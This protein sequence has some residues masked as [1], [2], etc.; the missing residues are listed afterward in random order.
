[1][2]KHLLSIVLILILLTFAAVHAPA[3][4]DSVLTVIPEDTVGFVY[5]PDLLGLNDEINTVLTELISTNPP[6]NIIA[7]RLAETFGA[8]FETLEELEELGLDLNK[9]FAVFLAGVNPLIPSAAVHLKDPVMVKQLIEMEAEGSRATTHNGMTYYTTGEEGA[10]VLLDDV[11]VYSGSTKVCE[12]AIDIYKKVIPSIATNADYASLE[13]DTTSGINDFVAY[14]A[15]EPIVE[16]LH[17][18]LTEALFE[19]QAEMQSETET[20]PQLATTLGVLPNMI[21]GIVGLLDQAKTL[22]ITLQLN[23]SDLQISPFLKFKSDSES[24]AYIRQ[25]PKELVQLNYLPQTAF[26]NGSMHLQQEDIIGLTTGMMRL[27]VP[28][29][30]NADKEQIE[31]AFQEFA[32][33]MTDFY[34]LLGDEMALSFNIGDSLMPD[35]LFVYDAPDEEKVKAYMEEGYLAYLRT[36]QLL[37]RA[38]GTGETADM[39]EGASAG[40]AEIYSGVEI[41]SYMLPNVSASFSQLPPEMEGLAPKQWNTY[42]AIKAGKLLLSMSANAQSIRD[43]LDRMTGM[44]TGFDQGEGYSKLIGALT[45]KNNMLFAI[46]PITVVKH[47]AQLIAQTDPNVGMILIILANIPETY[48]IGIASQNRD[49]GVEGKLFIS[50]S[51]FKE[52]INMAV[53][54]QEME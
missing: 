11:M 9:N 43:A 1:M 50:I 33:V 7:G 18:M 47:I 27:F 24:Q 20:N 3:E 12:K 28:P 36:P 48:G 17:P 29:N 19:M 38:M 34:K 16:I 46:S 39:F 45:L 15:A 21:D 51:D 5:A 23:G 10:F 2:E 49:G 4:I 6:Q 41:K 37:Y 54:M 25:P 42:Y 53:S 35:M 44:G 8:G 52:L 31:K 40:P 32:D 14:F 26:L 13:L 22:S 30:P